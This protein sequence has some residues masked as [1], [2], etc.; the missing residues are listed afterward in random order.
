MEYRE[1]DYLMLS[2]I[3]HFE[4]CRRQWALIHIEQIWK[5]N[6]RTVE[7][8]IMHKHAHNQNFT[9][10]RNGVITTRGMPVHSRK[11]GISGVCDIVEFLRDDINGYEIFQR[12]GKYRVLP[13][14]Y[15]KGK[16]KEGL[17]DIMQA[18]LQAICLEEMLCCQ[19]DNACLY[20][21]ETRRRLNVNLTSELRQRAISNIQEMHQYYERKYTPKV[22]TSKKCI[23]CS[24]KDLCVPKLMKNMSAVDY[25]TNMIEEDNCENF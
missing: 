7:G 15:K 5:E 13:V 8:N 3:Q 22:R 14:E 23:A 25:V 6:L 11:Y 19:I 18:V 17:E 16:P 12:Q 4:F 1:E 21:G 9:E 20:Y 2:G 24:L 10:N